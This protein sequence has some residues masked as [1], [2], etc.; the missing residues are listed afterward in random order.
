M[1]RLRRLRQVPLQDEES[2]DVG[3][4]VMRYGC[5]EKTETLKAA[6]S[7]LA[8]EGAAPTV[9]IAVPDPTVTRA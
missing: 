4:L 5:F 9:C 1:G 2:G 8:L 6:G 3:T 7:S